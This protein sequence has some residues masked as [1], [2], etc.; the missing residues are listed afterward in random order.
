MATVSSKTLCHCIQLCVYI[1]W[2][3][4]DFLV[5]V[6]MQIIAHFI[7]ITVPLALDTR[8]WVSQDLLRFRNDNLF[9]K[10]GTTAPICVYISWVGNIICHHSVFNAYT[11]HNGPLFD[12]ESYPKT[13]NQ[14]SCEILCASNG[15]LSCPG[16][17]RYKGRTSN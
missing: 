17:L 5:E 4:N 3:P 6:L 9:A 15:K 13:P 10:N 2:R 1:M 11:M 7:H 14:V 16:S 12:S 8:K